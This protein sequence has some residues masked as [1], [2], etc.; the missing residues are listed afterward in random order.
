MNISF[1]TTLSF[2]VVISITLLFQI[3]NNQYIIVK[4][5]PIVLPIFNVL[6]IPLKDK[7]LNVLSIVK[8]SQFNNYQNQQSPQRLVRR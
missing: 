3:K 1:I 2:I 5:S 7:L 6:S 4:L 8:Q